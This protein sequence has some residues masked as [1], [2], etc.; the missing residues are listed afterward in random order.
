MHAIRGEVSKDH[1]ASRGPGELGPA[2]LRL[3]EESFVLERPEQRRSFGACAALVLH[4]EGEGQQRRLSQG[5]RGHVRISP[6]ELREYRGGRR[7]PRRGGPGNRALEPNAGGLA[8]QHLAN[9]SEVL[10]VVPAV[11]ARQSMRSG[12]AVSGLPGKQR[13][14]RQPAL[15]REITDRQPLCRRGVCGHAVTVNLK[16]LSKIVSNFCLVGP[17]VKIKD[18]IAHEHSRNRIT[19]TIVES[20]RADGGA[21]DLHLRGRQTAAVRGAL[22]SVRSTAEP[23]A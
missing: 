22:V 13:G 9:E 14:W 23:D 21:P 15:A 10:V 11:A 17:A 19:L 6:A 2:G 20:T 16:K 12:K 8:T 7:P 18:R 5:L 4:R 3:P 1:R